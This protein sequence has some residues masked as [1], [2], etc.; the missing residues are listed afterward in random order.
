MNIKSKNSPIVSKIQTGNHSA[1]VLLE[2]QPKTKKSSIEAPKVNDQALKF[3]SQYLEKISRKNEKY[4]DRAGKKGVVAHDENLK[5]NFKAFK[6]NNSEKAEKKLHQSIDKITGGHK[7]WD[8]F[9]KEYHCAKSNKASD[10]KLD[11]IAEKHFKKYVKGNHYLS[12][13]DAKL[14]EKVKKFQDN[15]KL[16]LDLHKSMDRI[17]GGHNAWKQFSK[18]FEKL[19]KCAQ[20]EK[21]HADKSNNH[22][23]G[24]H[25]KSAHSIDT[26]KGKSL[27]LESNKPLSSNVEQAYRLMANNFVGQAA[28][29]TASLQSAPTGSTTVDST[30]FTPLFE[31]EG[32]DPRV[33]GKPNQL[34]FSGSSS[35]SNKSIMTAD[36]NGPRNEIKI[37]ESDTRARIDQQF[38]GLAATITPKFSGQYKAIIAQY[39]AADVSTLFKLYVDTR[40]NIEDGKWKPNPGQSAHPDGTASLYAKIRDPQNPDKEISISFGRIKPG[41]PIDFKFQNDHGKFMVSVNGQSSTYDLSGIAEKAG[42]GFLKIGDYNQFLKNEDGSAFV[43]KDG[44]RVNPVEPDSTSVT[45]DNFNYTRKVDDGVDTKGK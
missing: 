11:K 3:S 20:T 9:A 6:K 32:A 23:Q 43:M 21:S 41:D 18:K 22:K 5:A 44:K 39:H 13:Y 30:N 16:S 45:F 25:E 28:M 33:A 24:A 8:N 37:A 26:S 7:A 12:H 36:G 19:S 34:V 1:S 15:P 14:D 27:K 42:R 29:T 31:I 4:K 38:E 17:T 2:A 10:K 40:A 35:N